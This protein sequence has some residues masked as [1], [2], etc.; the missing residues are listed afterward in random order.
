LNVLNKSKSNAQHAKNAKNVNS[1]L[2]QD[3]L[4]LEVKTFN[5]RLN[6]LNS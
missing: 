3:N 4:M 1:Y 2:N 5:S 6:Q